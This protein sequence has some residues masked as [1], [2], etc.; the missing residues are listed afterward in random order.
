MQKVSPSPSLEFSSERGHYESGSRSTLLMVKETMKSD[1]YYIL[2]NV[3][4]FLASSMIGDYVLFG[5]A[6]TVV[7][8]V[9]YGI[10]CQQYQFFQK[11][12]IFIKQINTLA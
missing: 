11:K 5:F 2:E 3:V 9:L 8:T 4:E 6:Q 10:K 12:L 7:S 1:K